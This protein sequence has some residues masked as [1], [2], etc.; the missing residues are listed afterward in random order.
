[1]APRPAHL[2]WHHPPTTKGRFVFLVE[3]PWRRRPGMLKLRLLRP[4]RQKRRARSTTSSPSHRPCAAGSGWRPAAPKIA[5]RSS[6]QQTLFL[7]E[8]DHT[9][10]NRNCQVLRRILQRQRAEPGGRWLHDGRGFRPDRQGGDRP[11]SQH[12]NKSRLIMPSGHPGNYTSLTDVT[13]V[14]GR[15]AARKMPEEPRTWVASSRSLLAIGAGGGETHDCSFQR[16]CKAVW[17]ATAASQG[18]PPI[19]PFH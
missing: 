9:G 14:P 6:I 19:H 4:R 17:K 3:I 7:E 1:M 10:M 11:P 5:R 8:R 16:Q 15:P 2:P 12:H 18:P 13:Q